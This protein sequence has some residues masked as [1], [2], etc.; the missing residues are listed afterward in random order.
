[1]FTGDVFVIVVHYKNSVGDT[2]EDFFEG[3]PEQPGE[4]ILRRGAGQA[5][6][7][8][9]DGGSTGQFGGKPSDAG[10]DGAVADD[11]VD[12]EFE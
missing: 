1:M 11:D 2:A 7:E 9:D 4:S 5:V 3:E 12:F 10:A 8:V 6:G